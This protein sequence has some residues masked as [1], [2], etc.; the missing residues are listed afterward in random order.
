MRREDTDRLLSTLWMV[1]DVK[2]IRVI[3][4][5]GLDEIKPRDDLP[6]LIVDLLSKNLLISVSGDVLVVTSKIVSK[7]EGRV[8]P[9]DKFRPSRSDKVL[10]ER[11][12]KDPRLLC[13]ILSESRRIVR[14]SDGLIISQTSHGFICANAGVDQSNVA[15]GSVVL[16]PVDPDASA[17]RIKSRIFDEWGVDVAVVISD[18]FGRPWRE[19][20]T[21][22][23][24]GVA[25]M[26]A[27]LSYKGQVDQ[28]GYELRVTE[29]AVADELASAAELV[30]GKLDRIPV[31]IVRNYRF[32]RGE[33]G[34]SKL[35]RE[36]AKDLFR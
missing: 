19:G 7:S 8:V 11:I 4:V 20:Q 28:Y 25:G 22:V 26:D 16:L 12:G 23:A 18:T 31:V 35:I 17:R 3:G 33:G 27:T 24:I 13:A 5:E 36:P 2:E 21:C 30:M 29:I 15:K 9:L 6:S 10:A 1:L 14:M 34:A 32:K